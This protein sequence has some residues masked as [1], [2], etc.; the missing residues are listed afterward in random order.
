MTDKY[1]FKFRD[2]DIYKD[3]RIFRTTINKLLEKYPRSE[4]YA[5]VDQTKRALNSIL[6]N[7]AEGSNKYT[8]KDTRVYVTRSLGS[9]DEVVSCL[10]CA[11]DEDYIDPD[12]HDKLLTEASSI[13]QRLK[14][15]SSYL[16]SSSKG[17]RIK[18]QR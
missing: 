10:D 5:L 7:L 15:F 16:S 12:M 4:I 14:K 6:L 18:D 11:L 13:A 9:L 1:G 2:W 3:S 8:D 17:S